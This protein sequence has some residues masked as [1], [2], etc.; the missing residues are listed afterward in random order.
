[1]MALVCRSQRVEQGLCVCVL[2]FRPVAAFV[3]AMFAHSCG[4]KAQS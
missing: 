1:M 2:G 3:C 4:Q